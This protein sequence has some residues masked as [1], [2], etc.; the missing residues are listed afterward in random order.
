[1]SDNED[2]SQTPQATELGAL[3]LLTHN[4]LSVDPSKIK[5]F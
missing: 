3:A 2:T 4:P 1:M 5:I